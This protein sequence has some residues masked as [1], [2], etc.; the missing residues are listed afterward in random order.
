MFCFLF[1]SV[2]VSGIPKK[3]TSEDLQSDDLYIVYDT[4]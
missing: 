2:F 1:F 4:L 3:Y